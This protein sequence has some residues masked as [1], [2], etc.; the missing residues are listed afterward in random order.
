MQLITRN[1]RVTEAGVTFRQ[2]R[3]TTEWRPDKV[4]QVFRFCLIL[5]QIKQR[6]DVAKFSVSQISQIRELQIA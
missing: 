4:A 5:E 2:I 1:A 3:E 6:F